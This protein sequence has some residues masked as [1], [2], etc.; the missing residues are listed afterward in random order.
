MAKVEIEEYKGIK[1]LQS[2]HFYKFLSLA[3][4]AYTRWA[5]T[6]IIQRGVHG[7]DYFNLENP[8]KNDDRQRVWLRL[9]IT[10]D[11]AIGLTIHYDT[12]LAKSLRKELLRIRDGKQ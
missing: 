9:H 2:W 5:T 12:R 7:E 8:L 11:Y 6:H 3:P 4:S 10:L 1:V